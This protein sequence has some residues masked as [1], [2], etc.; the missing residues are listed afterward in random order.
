MAINNKWHLQHK[1]PKNPTIDERIQWH[2]EHEKN[3]QCRPIP[4]SL[5]KK[6]KELGI[7]NK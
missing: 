5:R 3:C 6:I 1:M 4:P 7:A 2:L